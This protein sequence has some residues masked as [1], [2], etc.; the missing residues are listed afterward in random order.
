MKKVAL[1]SLSLVALSGGAGLGLSALHEFN[2]NVQTSALATPDNI[3]ADSGF[4]IPDHVPDVA[5][6]VAIAPSLPAP[7]A[8]EAPVIEPVQ[9]ASL[10]GIDPESINEPG[11]DD[12][13]RTVDDSPNDPQPPVDRTVEDSP[14]DPQPPVVARA[15]VAQP[16]A[17]RNGQDADVYRRAPGIAPSVVSRAVVPT[18][19]PT[20]RQARLDFVIGV[21]R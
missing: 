21:Y 6:F 19:A 5:Q 1:L 11:T 18:P 16:T 13:D 15:P 4:I 20:V 7:D 9:T 8:V 3:Q 2:M 12:I 10:G 14:N 17:R